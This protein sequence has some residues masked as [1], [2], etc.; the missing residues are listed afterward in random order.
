MKKKKLYNTLLYFFL[1]IYFIIIK[2]FVAVNFSNKVTDF[3]LKIF[4]MCVK[5]KIT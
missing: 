2:L 3:S 1:K 5:I 4:K